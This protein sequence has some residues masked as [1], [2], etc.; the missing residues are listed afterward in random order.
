MG[1]ESNR[2]R[3]SFC[4][5]TVWM[6]TMTRDRPRRN[7]Q[8]RTPS[9][10]PQRWQGSP[11]AAFS[12][13][14]VGNWIRGGAAS[15]LTGIQTGCCHSSRCFKALCYKAGTGKHSLTVNYEFHENWS[16]PKQ[17]NTC[18]HCPTKFIFAFYKN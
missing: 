5:F 11:C 18:L 7:Q 17:T 16:L 14:L 3:S 13:T 12:G 9:G 6:A 10:S 15:N 2:V 1:R 8:P 4:L